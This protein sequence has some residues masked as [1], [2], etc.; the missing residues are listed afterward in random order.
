MQV[1]SDSNLGL[2]SSTLTLAAGST[3]SITGGT[4]AFT[5]VRPIPTLTGNAAIVVNTIVGGAT[6]GGTITSSTFTLSLTSNPNTALILT[7]NNSASLTTGLTFNY[8]AAN[9]LWIVTSPGNLGSG[10]AITSGTGGVAA[11][12]FLQIAGSNTFTTSQALTNTG[13]G[14]T[15]LSVVNPG[16]TVNWN[17][18]ITGT[19]HTFTV[20]GPGTLVLTNNNNFG[21]GGGVN[22]NVEGNLVEGN[23]STTT[24]T[25][26]GGGT[27]VIYGGGL[28]L[29]PA[30][31]LSGSNNAITTT[32]TTVTGGAILSLDWQSG[33]INTK[34]TFASL[35]RSLN[36][37]A[38]FTSGAGTLGTL[39]TGGSASNAVLALTSTTNSPI[40]TG[41]GI[42]APWAVLLQ[43][44]SHNADFATIVS[45]NFLAPYGS[46]AAFNGGAAGSNLTVYTSTGGANTVSV[47]SA[48]YAL[49]VNGTTI[50]LS[51]TLTLGNSI[52]VGSV[53]NNVGGLILN[54]GGSAGGAGSTISGSGTLAFGTAEG[55]IYVSDTS[56]TTPGY[57]PSPSTISSTISGSAGITV[58]GP[59]GGVGTLILGG[60]N[61]YTGGTRFNSGIVQVST[62]TTSANSNLGASGTNALT[63]NG[64]TL[65][66][67][68]SSAISEGRGITLNLGGG[69]IDVMNTGSTGNVTLTGTIGGS[70][71]LIKT[72]VGTLILTGSNTYTGATYISGGVLSVGG[73]TAATS[74]NNGGS[75]SAI[76]ESAS[77]PTNLVLSG[78]GILQYSG[79][80]ATNISTDRLFNLTGN[81]GLDA[82][83]SG[84]GAVVFTNTGNVYV[85]TTSAS[86][87]TLTGSSTAANT[88]TPVVTDTVV[89]GVTAA[90]T[91]AKTGVG[92]W[93]LA[94]LNTYSGGTTLAAGTLRLG[95]TNA[96]PVGTTVTF[97]TSTPTN[98]TLDLAGFNQT[99][100]GLAI[101]SAP[102]PPARLSATA[103]PPQLRP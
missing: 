67:N 76:G 99:V 18:A 66:Y 25:P 35:T 22:F 1:R 90:T 34:W 5:S 64:G 91:L 94:G 29:N 88:L 19:A 33:N 8:G 80:S 62:D 47:A 85:T 89:L 2:A 17:G 6:L 26:F 45:T 23:V 30:N 72:D 86:T 73:A 63:F 43:Q 97:G 53:T 3:L 92:T 11:V 68:N 10:T 36:G 79:S 39:T 59:S 28:Q 75:A 55:L 102:R 51:N 41:T 24:T 7:G 78:G 9:A 82:S 101:G 61:T 96:L 42:I 71:F 95:I 31:S 27:P 77:V 20:S 12:G 84:A 81:G 48:A 98:G 100:A 40:Q 21:S 60:A 4:S 58:F 56:S 57:T 16:E 46:Y 44:G 13:S 54:S 74:L 37:T 32:A 83:G 70:G 69:T 87:F 93:V 15:G 103:A 52:T 65:Q 14:A 50:T 38:V 49:Q